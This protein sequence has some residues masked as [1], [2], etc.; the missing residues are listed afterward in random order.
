MVREERQESVEVLRGIAA[1]A[2]MW[3]HLVIDPSLALGDGWLKASGAY[4]YLGVHLFFVISGFVI[5]YSLS[6]RGYRITTDGLGFLGRRVVRIEPAYLV[7]VLVMV[8]LQVA[9]A[10]TPGSGAAMPEAGLAASVALHVAYLAPWFDAP[11]LSPVYWTLAIEFQYYIVMLF[12]APLLLSKRRAAV[13]VV[14]LA[15][16][17]LPLLI[18]DQHL[19]FRYLPLFGLGFV[20]FLAF[21]HVL[22]RI[23]LASWAVLLFGLYWFDF[24]REQAIAAAVAF[25]FLF[26]PLRRPLPVLSFL[27]SISY[28]LYLIHFPV[29]SRVIHLV[30]RLPPSTAVQLAAVALA[31]IASVAAAY[32]Y[33]R[34]IERPSALFSKSIGSRRDHPA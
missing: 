12:L 9:S 13:S 3:F 26:L 27:G 18:G 32:A 6:V 22:T 1:F 23:E 19:L 31:G 11:W 5:P 34:L 8:A 7:S 15:T 28:S 20:R 16:A 29:G 21:R 17:V 25:G 24:S 33:W 10:L 4:G 30:M 14:L 2:V